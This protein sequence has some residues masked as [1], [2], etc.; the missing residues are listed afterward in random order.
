[1]QDIR[2]APD[3]EYE[4]REV[5]KNIMKDD[6]GW[7]KPLDPSNDHFLVTP[8]RLLGYATRQRIWGQICL[9]WAAPK[10]QADKEVFLR[11][12]RLQLP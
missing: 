2:I 10:K 3:H 1:M 4:F 9:D 5:V 12:L 6:P 11:K 7:E 8:P